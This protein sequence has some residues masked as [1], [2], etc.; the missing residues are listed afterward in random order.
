MENDR[1]IV[2]FPIFL[3]FQLQ[4]FFDGQFIMVG[5]VNLRHNYI[6]IFSSIKLM[7]LL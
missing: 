1:L 4:G 5:F 7:C 2:C 6:T 3:L